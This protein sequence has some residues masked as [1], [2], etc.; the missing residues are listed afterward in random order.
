MKTA[1]QI[2]FRRLTS[3]DFFNIN[4]LKGAEARGG[5]QSYIDFPISSVRLEDWMSFFSGQELIETDSGPLWRFTVNSIGLN[6]SQEAEIRG[7]RGTNQKVRDISLRKQKLGTSKSNR[8]YAWHPEYSG[9]PVPSD[10]SVRAG[11]PNNLV[12]YLVRTTG[13]EY[14]AGF[15]Q[16]SKPRTGWLVDGR[17]L[18]MFTEKNGNINL[19]PGVAFNENN[20]GWPFLN[21]ATATPA[22]VVRVKAGSLPIIPGKLIEP[23]P[24]KS[25]PGAKPV[26][27]Q[28]P[29]VKKPRYK[30]KSEG[31]IINELFNDDIAD[32][33]V[34]TKKQ[35]I[36]F[37]VERNQKIV[38]RLKKLYGSRCQLTGDKYVFKKI[39]GQLYCEAHH[40]IALG[41]G[42]ADSPYNIIIVS[43]LIHRMLHYADVSP[44]DLTKIVDNKL[45]ITING[46]SYTITW[47]AK[48][49]AVVNAAAKKGSSVG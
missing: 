20:A 4:K 15:F 25:K 33:A 8:L 43:P 29:T 30:T 14:W 49:A 35:A 26:A 36:I 5:G 44:L 42:G 6:K 22:Q 11:V 16:T 1:Q 28:I 18:Q 9:F 10:P 17:L 48:H 13:G 45:P 23:K 7:R 39:D 12:V 41:T 2:V 34:A 19:Y 27:T 24:S 21:G 47:H 37:V 32:E 31:Q 3:A 40:L 38:A 46:E